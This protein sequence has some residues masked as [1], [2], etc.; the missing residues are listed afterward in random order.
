[1]MRIIIINELVR[2]SYGNESILRERRNRTDEEICFK[3]ECSIC[4]IIIVTILIVGFIPDINGV[5]LISVFLIIFVISCACY[6]CSNQKNERE[7]NPVHSRNHNSGLN[8]VI[9]TTTAPNIAN[10]TLS[11]SPAVT[12]PPATHREDESGAQDLSWFS[13]HDLEA[14]GTIHDPGPERR[15]DEDEDPPPSFKSVIEANEEPPPKYE[16]C[17]R[18]T[19]VNIDLC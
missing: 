19:H 8:S 17:V 15:D 6:L 12:I 7:Q 2:Q 5:I 1:M 10:N 3:D 4:V 13:V 11:T 18:A 14:H 16:A 9:S